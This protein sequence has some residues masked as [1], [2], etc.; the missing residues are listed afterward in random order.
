MHFALSGLSAAGQPRACVSS[1]LRLEVP[2][3]RHPAVSRFKVEV[4][5][6]RKKVKALGFGVG[7]APHILSHGADISQSPTTPQES[8]KPLT[9]NYFVLS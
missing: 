2:A 4:T 7:V 8:L 5:N 6:K 9:R 1:G 3:R